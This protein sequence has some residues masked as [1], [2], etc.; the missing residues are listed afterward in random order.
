MAGEVPELRQS[1]GILLRFPV[2]VFLGFYWV[3]MVWWWIACL[4]LACS[5]ALLALMVLLPVLYP[6]AWCLSFLILAFKNSSDPVLPGYWDGYP[7]KYLKWS[8]SCI[9]HCIK[10]G[11]PTLH[12]WL[13]E[14]WHQH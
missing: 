6:F 11:F 5:I 12:R 7:D 9:R 3:L 13:R 4:G 10:L 8:E 14:G 2:V 1:V